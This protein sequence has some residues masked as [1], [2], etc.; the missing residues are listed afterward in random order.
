MKFAEFLTAVPKLLKETLPATDAHLLMAP[1]ERADLIRGIDPSSYNPRKA[2][3]LMLIYPRNEQAH[4]ALILRN[5][6]NGV[7]SS[8]IAFPGGKIE[9]VDSSYCMA[10]LRETHEEIGVPAELIN[11]IR[12]F[13][14][15]FIPPSNFMVFPFLGFSNEELIFTPDPD[16]VAGLI[17]FPLAN[18]LDE[19]TV[20]VNTM[21]T[22]YSK[23]ID[24]PTY[25][26]GEHHVWGATAMIMSELKVMLKKVLSA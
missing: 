11:V 14:E 6:Y 24:V 5:S 16:E 1:P 15:I 3:V 26:I 8:Q 4:L 12:A 9:P 19:E 20:V 22:S 10:A 2:A 21:A 7:H 18:F 13:T 23:S 17:E 25:K